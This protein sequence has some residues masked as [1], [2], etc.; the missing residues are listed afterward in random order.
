MKLSR[1]ILENIASGVLTLDAAGRVTWVNP[2]AARI[3]GWQAPRAIGRDVRDLVE[4]ESPLRRLLDD[5][6]SSRQFANDVEFSYQPAGSTA[7]RLRVSSLD[8]E[9]ETAIRSTVVLLRDISDVHRLEQQVVRA[10]KFLALGTLSAA[11]A[12]EIKNPLGALDL[13][14][15]LLA[16]ELCSDQP[17][18][19]RQADLLAVLKEEIRRLN[20]IVKHYLS[21]AHPAEVESAPVDLGRVIRDVLKLVRPELERRAIRWSCSWP[22]GGPAVSGDRDRLQQ[23]FLNLVLNA[24]E[25]MPG[26]GELRVAAE[27]GRD[28]GQTG[29]RLVVSVADTGPGIPQELLSRIFDPYFTTRTEGLGLGLAVVHRIV[30]DHGGSVVVDS[31]LDLGTTFTVA[32]PLLERRTEGDAA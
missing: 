22:D 25:A 9:T 11:I 15:D 4:A 31:R 26:G 18:P 24:M 13:N 5:A 32:L 10:E 27:A 7:R 29:A 21:F 28:V 3:L 8:L 14:V 6:L 2:A 17:D 16:D 1:G 19:G 23:L 20:S 30:E 12:H